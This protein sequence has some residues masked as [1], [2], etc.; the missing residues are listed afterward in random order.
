MQHSTGE[1]GSGSSSE[2]TSSTSGGLSTV[3][4]L[5]ESSASFSCPKEKMN[6][7]G[8]KCDVQNIDTG[9]NDDSI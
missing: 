4:Q 2:S 6:M 5:D 8:I 3:L 1:M 7:D 9:M